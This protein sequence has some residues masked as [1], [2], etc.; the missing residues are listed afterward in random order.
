MRRTA[1]VTL[2]AAGLVAAGTG[3]SFAAKPAPAPPAPNYTVSLVNATAYPDP[4][5]CL[6]LFQTSFTSSPSKLPKDWKFAS[7]TVAPPEISL[8]SVGIGLAYDGT[9]TMRTAWADEGQTV[10]VAFAPVYGRKLGATVTRQET[11]VL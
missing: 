4:G 1:L 11:C 9:S 3:S 5:G 10:Y 8:D 7:S 6:Y 2:L